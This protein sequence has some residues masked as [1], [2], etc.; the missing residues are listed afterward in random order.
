MVKG[1]SLEL[2]TKSPS[3]Q[4]QKHANSSARESCKW[5]ESGDWEAQ[6]ALYMFTSTV[7]KAP[8]TISVFVETSKK[9]SQ[10]QQ[11]H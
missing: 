1:E 4:R 6:A 8:S 9:Q 3:S 5:A 7:H 11:R 2:K 10:R